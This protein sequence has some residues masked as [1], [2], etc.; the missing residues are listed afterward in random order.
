MSQDRSRSLEACALPLLVPVVVF[1]VITG[2]SGS[3]FWLTT[4]FVLSLLFPPAVW[5]VMLWR[6]AKRAEEAEQSLIERAERLREQRE[7][8]RRRQEAEAQARPTAAAAEPVPPQGKVIALDDTPA[9]VTLMSLTE[10]PVARAAAPLGVC[11]LC[12]TQIMKREEYVTCPAC[13]TKYHPDCW[14]YNEGCAVYG[15]KVR[16]SR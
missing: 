4:L 13:K 7:E 5:A 11:P 9:G 16:L 14:E 8:R 6:D 1:A 10:M 3:T 12:Q 2:V 15:C